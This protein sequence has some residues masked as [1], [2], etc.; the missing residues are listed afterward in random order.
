VS[1]CECC[2][3]SGGR[4]REALIAVG[5]SDVAQRLALPRT[6]TKLV[7]ASLCDRCVQGAHGRDQCN[8][9]LASGIETF[10]WHCA[11]MAHVRDRH[12]DLLE[13]RDKRPDDPTPGPQLRKL[14]TLHVQEDS[15]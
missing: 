6:P 1:T 10:V 5:L 2:R 7:R 3:A 15:I 9:C 12:A 8:I 11:R 4:E 14:G 13:K